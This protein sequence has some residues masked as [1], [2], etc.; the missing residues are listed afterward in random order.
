MRWQQW[1]VFSICI[2]ILFRTYISPRCVDVYLHR[3]II[4]K[5]NTHG[6]WTLK[7][8]SP[9]RTSKVFSIY[10]NRGRNLYQHSLIYLF[11]SEI[12]LTS[13][14]TKYVVRVPIYLFFYFFHHNRSYFPWFWCSIP[15]DYELIT[16]H[17]S[18]KT[19]LC[20]RFCKEKHTWEITGSTDQLTSSVTSNIIVGIDVNRLRAGTYLNVIF[21]FLMHSGWCVCWVGGGFCTATGASKCAS[22]YPHLLTQSLSKLHF[23]FQKIQVIPPQPLV[24]SFHKW[25]EC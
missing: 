13:P 16:A 1:H 4:F 21:G 18:L 20:A 2:S 11:F 10:L 6:K 5:K 9:L 15:F 8:W 3:T 14:P 23:F 25:S 17:M 12:W 7:F 19:I 24:L 22:L